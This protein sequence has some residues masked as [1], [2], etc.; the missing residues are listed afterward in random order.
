MRIA[1]IGPAQDIHL[2]RWGEALKEAGAEVFFFGVEPPSSTQYNNN[3]V[4]VGPPTEKPTWT[5]FYRRRHALREVLMEK[6]ID[7]AHPIHLTPSGVWVWLSQF[8]PYVPFAMGADVLEYVS[9]APPLSRS[10]TFQAHSPS[11]LSVV[12]AYGRRFLYPFLLSAVL[13]E[14]LFAVGDNYQICISKK[15][16]KKEKKYI[17][18][19]AGI[20]LGH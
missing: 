16:F 19:P 17:E 9:P 14:A 10:W 3:Y 11:L 20:F 13:E 7:I 8:R 12:A 6:R 1:L 18:L 4:C 2:N 15:N 5:T